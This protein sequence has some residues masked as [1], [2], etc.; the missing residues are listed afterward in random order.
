MRILVVH[1][2]YQ[3]SG[4]E[5]NVAAAEAELLLSRGHSVERLEFD[6]DHIQGALAQIGAAAHSMYSLPAKARARAAIAQSRPDLVHVHNFFP[7]LS[8][9]VFYACA[10]AGVPVVHTLHNFRILCA[11]ATLFRDGRVCEECVSQ[12]S[13]L[14]GVRH[15]CYRGSRAGSAVTGFGMALHDR[16]GTWAAKVSAFIALTEFSRD[17]LGSFRLPRERIFV[18]PNFTADRGIGAGSGEYALFVGRLSPE[19]GLQTLMDADRAGRLAMDMVL[20]GDGPLMPELTRAAA[21]PGSRLKPQGF[22]P[23]ESV[24]AWMREARVLLMPSLWYEGF[25]LVLVEALSLGLPV[26]AAGHGNLAALIE[27]GRTG[28]LYPPGDYAALAATLAQFADRPSA[29]EAMRRAARTCYLERYTP[30]RNY[31]DLVSIYDR[32]LKAG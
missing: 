14:P 8:P 19:K 3:Q 17:K 20:L 32:V 31:R 5:D 27:H 28:L 18:K 1:N 4:G 2:R 29:A 21:R 26:I 12:R 9:S 24:L 13:F 15:A 25:P 16:L 10:E 11:G 22:Q 23:R 30:E 6:N 7:T